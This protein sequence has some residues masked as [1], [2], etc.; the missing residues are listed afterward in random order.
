MAQKNDA[1]TIA[2]LGAKIASYQY[3]IAYLKAFI[4]NSAVDGIIPVYGM[5]WEQES[6]LT[7][8]HGA[9]KEL[10]ERA[11]RQSTCN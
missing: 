3:A 1:Q 7:A 9:I 5:D 10:K 6:E 11:E 2:E 4:Y 8:L